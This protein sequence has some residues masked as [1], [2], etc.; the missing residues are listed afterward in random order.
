MMREQNLRRPR[1]GAGGHL[2]VCAPVHAATP[3]TSAA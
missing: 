3:G 1:H 2:V